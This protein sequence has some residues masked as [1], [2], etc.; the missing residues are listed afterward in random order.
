MVTQVKP[1]MYEMFY[2]KL[3]CNIRINLMTSRD[4]MKQL[5]QALEEASHDTGRV[6]LD[7]YR[8]LLD[9]E[10]DL[11]R[12]LDSEELYLYVLIQN[13]SRQLEMFRNQMDSEELYLY[14]LSQNLS[15]QLGKV[16]REMDSEEL[17]LYDLKNLTGQLEKVIKQRDD[18]QNLSRQ[19]DK[20]IRERDERQGELNELIQNLTGQLD[21]VTRER[22]EL[23]GHLNG[24][25]AELRKAKETIQ[26]LSTSPGGQQKTQTPS[27]KSEEM[28][29]ESLLGSKNDYLDELERGGS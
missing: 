14:E 27:Q 7:F 29:M 20:V 15:R 9:L 19:L 26:S 24:L 4:Q 18:L 23:Q 21:K 10:P 1:I 6:K 22:D 12:D 11:V 25:K 2:A 28:E 8:I 17:Y 16:I 13:L 5:Y 3:Y